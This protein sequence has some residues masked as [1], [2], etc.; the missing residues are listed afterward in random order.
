MN[1]QKRIALIALAGALSVLAIAGLITWYQVGMVDRTG[2]FGGTVGFQHADELGGSF[3]LTDQSGAA[4]SPGDLETPY[5]LIY[6]G[7]TACPDVCPTELQDM[8]LALDQMDADLADQVTPAFITI[9]PARD[10]VAAVRDYV[11][12]FHPRMIGLTGDSQAIETV[13]K[14]YRVFYSRVASSE[15]EAADS[16]MMDHSSFYYLID[17][18]G[19]LRRMFTPKAPID[20][21][22]VALGETVDEMTPSD[23]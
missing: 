6:F 9:D 8:T 20:A 10:D 12:H 15:G 13:A 21:L 7:F 2:G 5:A 14:L 11:G 4:F 3:T 17:Q 18:T 1:A 16:Y 19:A 22:S 23:R